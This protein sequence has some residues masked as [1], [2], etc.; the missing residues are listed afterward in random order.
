MSHR[1]E[2]R[3]EIDLRKVKNVRHYFDVDP[4]RIVVIR[5]I[6]YDITFGSYVSFQ[7]DSHSPFEQFMDVMLLLFIKDTLVVIVDRY[8][9]SI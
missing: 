3:L 9:N 1:S 6:V 8:H 7:G 4:R 5:S 2:W